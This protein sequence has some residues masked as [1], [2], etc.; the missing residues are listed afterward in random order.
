MY[1]QNFDIGDILE[2]AIIDANYFPT[3][4]KTQFSN[5]EFPV[6]NKFKK[7]F[8]DRKLFEFWICINFKKILKLKYNIILKIL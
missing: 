2:G 4:Q 7:K 6:N 8:L 5:S 1:D 3:F